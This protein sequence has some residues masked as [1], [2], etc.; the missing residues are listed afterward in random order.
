MLIPIQHENMRARRWPVI[1]LVLIVINVACFLFTMARMDRESSKQAQVV[2]AHILILAASHPELEVKPET[3]ELIDQVKAQRPELWKEMSSEFRPIADGWDAQMRMM[4]EKEQWQAEMER[5]EDEYAKLKT[6]NLA[7]NYAFVPGRKNPISYL[8]ANFLHGGWMHLIGNMWFLWLAG[9]VLED[10]WGRPLYTV[11]YLLAGAGALQFYALLNP[12]S[13]TPTLG[14]SGAVAG[15]MGAF[16]V[17]F[18]KIRIEMAWIWFSLL[19]FRVRLFRFKVPAYALLPFWFATEVLSGKLFGSSMG[20]AHWAHVGGFLF[21]AVFAL[22]VRASGIEKAL[23]AK[24]TE[25]MEYAHDPEIERATELI[26]SGRVQEATPILE[27]YVKAKPDS[28]DGWSLLQQS[29]WRRT[30]LQAYMD[31]SLKLLALH[32]EAR[33]MESCER[34]V[35]DYMKGGGK[36]LPPA[37][38]LELGAAYEKEQEWD[39]AVFE[40]ENLAT[41]YPALRDTV[42]AKL[43]AAHIYLNELQRPKD[44]LRHYREAAQSLVSHADLSAKIESGIKE[45]TAA[46]QKLTITMEPAHANAAAAAASAGGWQGRGVSVASAGAESP[47]PEIMPTW[48]ATA[49]A[50]ATTAADHVVAAASSP[51][52]TPAWTPA[53]NSWSA[54]P[55]TAPAVK[56]PGALKPSKPA[57]WGSLNAPPVWGHGAK[58]DTVEK[59]SSIPGKDESST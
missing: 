22:G 57:T 10:V 31:A 53:K 1:T 42:L 58:G 38:W 59:P 3:Q 4:V 9:F 28:M 48:A 16:L 7:E 30:E 2:R 49:N 32:I 44:A 43:A 8:T 54:S 25:E 29:Y 56:A 12:G 51:E 17:R 19:R 27:A 41:A 26:H 45:A 37:L 40:Y 23:T 21:G 55:T 20:V 13:L 36:Q 35:A 52:I 50:S 18:P 34:D 6:D 15:L 24:V 5:L 11:F 46:S 47:S 14:A 39:R 33:D